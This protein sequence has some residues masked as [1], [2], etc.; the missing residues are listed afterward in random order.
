LGSLLPFA[1]EFELAI[2]IERWTEEM[3]ES[4]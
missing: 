2:M 1:G 4:D 3:H